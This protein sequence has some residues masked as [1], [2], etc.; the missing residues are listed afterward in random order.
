MS[1][2][3]VDTELM[4]RALAQAAL[5]L[6]EGSMP[7]G[8][9]LARD[10]EV[11][12]EAH[13]RGV[14]QGLLTHPE[15]MV[16]MAADARVPAATRNRCLLVTTLEPCLMCMGTAMSF[17]VGQI[18]Y[19]LPAPE[20]GAADVAA[21]WSPRQG[22]PTNGV[23]YSLPLVEGGVAEDAA[24]ALIEQWLATGVTGGEAEFAKRTLGQT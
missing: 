2:S 4:K 9:V 8:A 1:V 18:V 24:R 13:W 21:R 22:H 5:G 15:H 17:G 3:S 20:D 11:L 12:E 16:L 6:D 19:A 7:I 10:D 23:P 14:S